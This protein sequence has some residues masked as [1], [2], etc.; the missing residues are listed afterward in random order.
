MLSCELER[1][2]Y[3]STYYCVL[4]TTKIVHFVKL[5]KYEMNFT[6]VFLIKMVK[7]TYMERLIRS[8]DEGVNC[9]LCR[10]TPHTLIRGGDLH[11][12]A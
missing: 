12:I 4:L 5:S 6:I 3:L 2:L 10:E 7:K 9:P 1:L 8:P 11:Y